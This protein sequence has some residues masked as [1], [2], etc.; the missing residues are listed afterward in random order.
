MG[1]DRGEDCMDGYDSLRRCMSQTLVGN[2]YITTGGHPCCIEQNRS[3]DKE[4]AGQCTCKI[5]KPAQCKRPSISSIYAPT[6]IAP[7]YNTVREGSVAAS[8]PAKVKDITP[9]HCTEAQHQ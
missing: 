4:I 7:N 1:D 6:S 3:D 2:N 9:T 8:T 5:R